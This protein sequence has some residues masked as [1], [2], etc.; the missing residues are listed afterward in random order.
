MK[1]QLDFLIEGVKNIKEVGALTRSGPILCKKMISPVPSD[2][3]VIVV[4]LGAGDG[5]ITKHLLK[6]IT[7]NSKVISIELNPRLFKELSKIEDPKLI[8][9]NDTMDNLDKI[10]AK[11]GIEKIDHM[12]SAIPFMIMDN[13]M[14][15]NYLNKYK[16]FIKTNGTFTQVHYAYKRR[17]YEKIFGNAK[18]HFVPANVPP[19]IVVESKIV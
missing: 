1:K 6:K 15:T 16:E 8:A 2:K 3:D 4:E 12:V 10:L 14:V 19:A 7:A 9:V 11:H 18:V 5:V 13:N 17:F